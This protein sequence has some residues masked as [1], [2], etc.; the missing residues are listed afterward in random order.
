MSEHIRM[1]PIG[2]TRT[3]RFKVAGAPDEQP[4]YR[5]RRKTMRP[6]MVSITYAR[7]MDVREN[8]IPW[9][10]HK[11]EVLG[12]VV[13]KSGRTSVSEYGESEYIFG[14]Y[15]N[16]AMCWPDP[17]PWIRDLATLHPTPDSFP[18]G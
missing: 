14:N 4:N 15:H 6:Y 12:D 1:D 5:N 11:M 18:Q 16:G 2:E 17:P 10:V 8:L 13:L 3:I 7:G 9:H